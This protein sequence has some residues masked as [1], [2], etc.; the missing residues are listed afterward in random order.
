MPPRNRFPAGRARCAMSSM[1]APGTPEELSAGRR[2]PFLDIPGASSVNT[3][4]PSRRCLRRAALLFLGHEPISSKKNGPL[5]SHEPPCKRRLSCL[6]AVR[7]KQA[8]RTV[9][10]AGRYSDYSIKGR[11]RRAGLKTQWLRWPEF[12]VFDAYVL[13]FQN[14]RKLPSCWSRVRSPSP[15]PLRSCHPSFGFIVDVWFLDDQFP[16]EA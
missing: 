7:G 1:F 8:S 10:Q 9:G 2:S 6:S 16:P 4:A 5:G 15:A 12:R 3:V 13:Y 11:L 14:R